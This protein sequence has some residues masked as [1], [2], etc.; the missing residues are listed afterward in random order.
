MTRLDQ[1]NVLC[2]WCIRAVSISVFSRGDN[3]CTSKGMKITCTAY[4]RV[5][6]ITQPYYVFIQR[7]LCVASITPRWVCCAKSRVFMFS[8]SD[9]FFLN[10]FLG[11]PEHCVYSVRMCYRPHLCRPIKWYV[12]ARNCIGPSY[13]RQNL[14]IQR[15]IFGHKCI[16]KTKG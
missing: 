13:F 14:Y 15:Y 4:S 10:T 16:F 11:Y 12:F 8:D 9:R 7:L 6:K 1:D 5:N 2:T 3:F